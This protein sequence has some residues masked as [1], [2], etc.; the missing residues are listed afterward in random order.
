[1][2]SP[3]AL[4]RWLRSRSS[5][6]RRDATTITESR[7]PQRL[8]IRFPF[9]SRSLPPPP[10]VGAAPG[11]SK[12]TGGEPAQGSS[13]ED[14]NGA[15]IAVAILLPLVL[16]AAIVL[17]CRTGGA[18]VELRRSHFWRMQMQTRPRNVAFAV[19]VGEHDVVRT[20]G[21]EA[22]DGAAKPPPRAAAASYLN[23]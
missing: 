17:V 1:M 23:R 5:T 14:G 3:L 4:S 11:A 16:V 9:P 19:A 20:V 12:S 6:R 8:R 10:G 13:K 7:G 2:V 18:L 21:V 22:V 15:I